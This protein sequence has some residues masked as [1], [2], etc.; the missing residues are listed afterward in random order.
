M[1]NGESVMLALG[2]RKPLCTA[3]AIVLQLPPLT[4]TK[5]IM[6]MSLPIID[7]DLYLNSRQ[8]AVVLQECKKANAFNALCLTI[9][10]IT[11]PR[12]PML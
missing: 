4:R 12:L 6:S 2:V 10:E 1:V 11:F 5:A 3:T 9:I 8:P 7:I